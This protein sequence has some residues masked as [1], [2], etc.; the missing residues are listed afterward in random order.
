VGVGPKL[1]RGLPKAGCDV[2]DVDLGVRHAEA[3]KPGI[4]APLHLGSAKKTVVR[5]TGAQ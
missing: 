5:I 2:V 1:V 4:K 3:Q